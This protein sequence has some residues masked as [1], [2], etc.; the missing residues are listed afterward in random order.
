[1]GY[2]YIL[3]DEDEAANVV[4]ANR[5]LVHLGN[6]QIPKGSA[7]ISLLTVFARDV[8]DSKSEF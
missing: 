7:V 3:V 2:K 6:D 4:Y 1:V 8:T 5:T